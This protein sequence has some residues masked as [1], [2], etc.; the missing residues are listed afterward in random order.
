M[1]KSLQDRLYSIQSKVPVG[2]ALMTAAALARADD[3]IDVS[4]LTPKIAAGATAMAVLGLAYL[5]ITVVK[6][7]WGKLGG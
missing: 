4:S 3:T 5:A 7:L 2:V 1:K 6:K